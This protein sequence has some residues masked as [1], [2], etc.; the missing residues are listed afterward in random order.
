MSILV[1]LQHVTRYRYDAPAVLGPHVIKLRP[2]PHSRTRVPSYSL[3]VAPAHQVNWQHDP[4]GNWAARYLFSERSSELTVTVDLL[5]EIAAYN[6]FDF[7]I[8]PYAA[9]FP[10]AYPDELRRELSIFLETVSGGPSPVVAPRIAPG[11]WARQRRVPHR[12]DPA[13]VGR[14]PIPGAD[15]ARRAIVRGD[16]RARLRLV[17]RHRLAAGAGA[18][19]SRPRRPLRLRLSHPAQARRRAA[20]GSA[21]P[22]PRLV[23]P[24]CL[25]RR[26]SAGRRLDRARSDLRTV[27]RR[28]PPA[29][30][31]D[32]TLRL[33]G[34]HHRLGRSP[35]RRVHGRDACRAR[36]RA[37]ARDHADHR[38]NVGAARRLG[39]GGRPGPQRPGRAPHLRRRAYLRRGR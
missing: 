12:A 17:P 18:A 8:E 9:T 39:R 16:A 6:P 29:A 25:G 26:L 4:H 33:R 31:R 10:F 20:R 35:R 37:A 7:F 1:S 13:I 38:R 23:R 28:R 2:A 21:W 3:Q 22:E 11:R 15:G 30:R 34:A 5:A 27:V 14:H 24:A 19:P 36:R 32:P